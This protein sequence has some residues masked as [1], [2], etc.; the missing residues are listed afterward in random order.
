MMTRQFDND[1]VLHYVSTLLAMMW[2]HSVLHF[3][4]EKL[5]REET[6]TIS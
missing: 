6:Q 2:E 1:T 4:D 3:S 5:A